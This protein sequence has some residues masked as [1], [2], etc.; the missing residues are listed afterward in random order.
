MEPA[1]A[2]WEALLGVGTTLTLAVIVMIAL[3]LGALALF[4]VSSAVVVLERFART[5]TQVRWVTLFGAMSLSAWP[6]S[7]LP[8]PV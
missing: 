8:W 3:A 1:T 2:I 6:A 4:Y 5:V 7:W